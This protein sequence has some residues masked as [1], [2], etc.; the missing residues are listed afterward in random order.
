MRY[1][2]KFGYGLGN[3]RVGNLGGCEDIRTRRGRKLEAMLG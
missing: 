1:V 3:S 2:R